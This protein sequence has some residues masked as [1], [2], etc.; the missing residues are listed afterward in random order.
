MFLEKKHM[1]PER[2][3][4]H[5]YFEYN[6]FSGGSKNPEKCKWEGNVFLK[7]YVSNNISSESKLI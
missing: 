7:C 1:F 2:E 4:P 5:L 6:S 3:S